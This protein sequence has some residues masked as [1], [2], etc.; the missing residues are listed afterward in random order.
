MAVAVQPELTGFQVALHNFSGPFDL[1]LHLIGTRQVEITEVALAEIT[2]EFIAYTR[3]LADISLDEV[4]S[5]LVV[6]STLVELKAARLVP[7]HEPETEEELAAYRERE[8]L[9]VHLLQYQAFRRVADQFREWEAAARHTYP[10]EVSLEQPF[11]HQL[12]PVE[13]GV[14]TDEFAL[15]AA[16]V[17]RPHPTP[18][19]D[20]GHIHQVHVSV[21]HEA[22]ELLGQLERAGVG[23]WLTFT[24][25]TADCSSSMQVVGRFLGLLELVKAQAATAT[26]PEPLSTISVT[27]TGTHVDP[28]VVASDSWE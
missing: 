8:L 16:A 7:Q 17:F 3:A 25:L 13:L 23:Q 1:L 11:A 26:Q 22:G 10:R 6:A 19:V 4:T 14:D 18:Q 21:P 28:R 9:L 15:L 12:A 24:Q 27:W 5:F 20:V 2:E